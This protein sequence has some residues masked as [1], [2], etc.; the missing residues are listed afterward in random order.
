M[1]EKLRLPLNALFSVVIA[2]ALIGIFMFVALVVLSPIRENIRFVEKELTGL[3]EHKA[4]MLTF[5]SINLA[6]DNKAQIHAQ[7][8]NIGNESNLI[9]DP[10]ISSYY[11]V[12]IAVK[13]LP[14]M[15][16]NA[17]A[18]LQ[19]Y[20]TQQIRYSLEQVQQAGIDTQPIHEALALLKHD[21]KHIDTLYDTTTALLEA[22]L[23]ERLAKETT[24]LWQQIMIMSVL[25]LLFSALATVA[26]RYYLKRKTYQAAEE[27]LQLVEML[28]KANAELEHFS[29]FTAHDL[30]EPVRTIACFAA[31]MEESPTHTEHLP[32]IRKA[33]LRMET[34]I[35]DV[36]AY[37]SSGESSSL[38]WVD[39]NEVVKEVQEDLHAI[40]TSTGATFSFEL[41][42]EIRTSRLTLSRVLQNIIANAMHYRKPDTAPH[43]NIEA[44]KQG[45][46]WVF[47]VSDNGMGFDMA[48]AEQV[49]EPFKRLHDA[50]AKSSGIGLSICKKLLSDIG[51]DI[52]IESTPNV[53]TR[54]F[55]KLPAA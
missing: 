54:V 4:L 13:L 31:L 40:I 21:P 28:E 46:D 53:G 7:L 42:P 45:N 23:N 8:R 30:K 25:F 9:L 38:E 43:I 51:G 32:T 33:A 39:V 5:Q 24:R 26:V 3:H 15:L 52:W 11:L 27:R 1:R 34:L 12:N 47:S 48:Y 55:F 44:T 22:E 29:Y 19:T 35:N 37:L 20:F 18:S 50:S 6:Q 36:L 10:E 16:L 2:A 17:D 41:L 49:F 14:D